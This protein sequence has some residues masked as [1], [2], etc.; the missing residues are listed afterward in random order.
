MGPASR[1]GRL[2]PSP[3]TVEQAVEK[4]EEFIRLFTKSQR[5]NGL[6]PRRAR[7]RISNFALKS[8]IDNPEVSV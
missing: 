4:R 8:G 3:C 2:S 5:F 1:R 6:H 7:L